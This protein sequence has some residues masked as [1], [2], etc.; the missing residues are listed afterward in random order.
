MKP[1]L[2][3][4]IGVVTDK[5]VELL[6]EVPDLPAENP[7]EKVQIL[8]GPAI[9]TGAYEADVVQVG[10]GDPNEPAAIVQRTPQAG[11]GRQAYRE[12]IELTMLISCFTGDTDMK[13]VRDRAIDV[14]DAVK[15]RLDAHLVVEDVWDGLRLG[16]AE[17]WYQ[18]QDDQGSTS[19]VGFTVIASSIV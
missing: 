18:V 14:F 6:R 10:P 16:D 4:R 15:E 11:L 19:Y 7:F 13:Q 1:Q 9:A 17:V 2:G 12:D 3:S 5:V 8:D